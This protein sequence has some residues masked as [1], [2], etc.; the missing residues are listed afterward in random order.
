M[1]CDGAK[2]GTDA[3]DL[4]QEIVRFVIYLDEQVSESEQQFLAHWVQLRASA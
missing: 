2:V 3:Q 1:L 4:F